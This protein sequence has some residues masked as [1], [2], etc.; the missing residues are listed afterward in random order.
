MTVQPARILDISTFL[1]TWSTKSP[2]GVL[3]TNEE[4]EVVY[5]NEVCRRILGFD[6]VKS[7]IGKSLDDIFDHEV[8]QDIWL[9][10]KKE[11]SWEGTV[12]H[13]R[14]GFGGFITHLTLT[15]IDITDGYTGYLGILRDVTH[16]MAANDVVQVAFAEETLVKSIAEA[17][18]MHDDDV[19]RHIQTV[20][21][22]TEVIADQ[23][24]TYLLGTSV[25]PIRKVL[26]QASMLHDVGMVG[27][28]IAIQQK[29]PEQRSAAEE[30]IYRRHTVIGANMFTS[31]SLIS[32]RFPGASLFLQ[33]VASIARSHHEHWDGSGWPY[34]LKGEEIPIEARIVAIADAYDTYRTGNRHRN[35]W[36]H[37]RVMRYICDLTGVQFDPTI[38]RALYEVADRVDAIW[39]ESQSERAWSSKRKQV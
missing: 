37:R 33:T 29:S 1:R 24:G 26:P 19:P 15:H 20:K 6:E 14:H 32:K 17:S 2:D 39:K 22:I 21:R 28:P 11:G 5:A 31:P 9:A 18:E 25:H 34:G 13:T 3:I 8:S 30:A 38:S 12:T 7:I 23:V 16:L 10:L 27:V 35:G 4:H 36:Q